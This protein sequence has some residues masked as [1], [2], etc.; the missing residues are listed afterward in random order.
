MQR[1]AVLHRRHQRSALE[2]DRSRRHG[3]GRDV[4]MHCDQVLLLL[5]AVSISVRRAGQPGTGAAMPL[6]RSTLHAA[7]RTQRAV[8]SP[9]RAWP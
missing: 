2:L 8:H 7:G 1:R 4:A 9:W 6:E 5:G 3:G